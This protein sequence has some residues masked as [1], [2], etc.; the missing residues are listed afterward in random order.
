ME[1]IRKTLVM[2]ARHFLRGGLL[3]MHKERIDPWHADPKPALAAMA[4]KA[5]EIF[6]ANPDARIELRMEVRGEY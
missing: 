4:E 2:E 5:A 3:A 1:G 6:A